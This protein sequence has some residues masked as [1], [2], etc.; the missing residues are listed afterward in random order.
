LRLYNIIRIWLAAQFRS[1]RPYLL[2]DQEQMKCEILELRA[3]FRFFGMDTSDMSDEDILRG[4]EEAGRIL[5]KARCTKEEML[6]VDRLFNQVAVPT[7]P[8]TAP[9]EPEPS[10]SSDRGWLD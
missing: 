1:L 6:E 3:C 10:T 5:S 7:R 8:T 9:P 4:A 2:T